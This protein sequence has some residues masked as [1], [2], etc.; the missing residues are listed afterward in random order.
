MSFPDNARAML[1][2]IRVTPGW[3]GVRG[4][5]DD[6][7][8]AAILDEAARVAEEVV[9]PLNRVGDRAGAVFE[10]GAVRVP[11]QYRPAYEALA[12]GGWIGLEQDAALGGQGLPLTL[13]VAVNQLFERAAPAFMMAAGGSRAA[14]RLLTVWADEATRADWVPALIEGR[15]TASI[16]ISEPEAGSD[17]GRIRTKAT[18]GPDGWRLTGQKIWISFGDHDLAPRIGHCV[19]ART[20]DAPGTRGLSLF[21]VE[22]GPGV[23]TLRRMRRGHAG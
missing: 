23:R 6:E 15:A 5:L 7:D 14:A 20:S 4:E 1:D 13:F 12:E 18:R 3:G 11:P 21:L 8:V 16:C 10:A 19:L 2:A 22:R 9:A 17:V